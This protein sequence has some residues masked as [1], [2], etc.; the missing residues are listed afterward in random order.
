MTSSLLNNL[1]TG[2][3]IPFIFCLCVRMRKKVVDE[4]LI[5]DD[6]SPLYLPSHCIMHYLDGARLFI[7]YSTGRTAEKTA[8]A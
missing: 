7:R 1:L 3:L 4:S 6:D 2:D 8:A 5:K